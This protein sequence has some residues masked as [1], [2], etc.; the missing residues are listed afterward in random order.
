[1]DAQSVLDASMKGTV[2]LKSEVRE[3]YR[4]NLRRDNRGTIDTVA[5]EL[6]YSTDNITKV[7]TN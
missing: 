4:G 3:V 7:K 5:T 2:S 1:M 6:G